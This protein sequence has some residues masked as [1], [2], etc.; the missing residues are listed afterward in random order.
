MDILS[1]PRDTVGLELPGYVGT[2]FFYFPEKSA[3]SE[4]KTERTKTEM[5]FNKVKKILFYFICSA[6]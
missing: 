5:L 1:G 4:S 3:E 6:S 2:H